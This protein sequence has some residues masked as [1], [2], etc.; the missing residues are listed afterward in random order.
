M[1]L[2]Q[3]TNERKFMRRNR[4]LTQTE[5]GRIRRGICPPTKQSTALMPQQKARN[6]L[7][8]T[9][10]KVRIPLSFFHSLFSID[11]CVVRLRD[12]ST[13][14]YVSILE[15]NAHNPGQKLRQPNK[16]TRK[17]TV[18]TKATIPTILDTRRWMNLRTQCLRSFDTLYLIGSHYTFPAFF[19]HFGSRSYSRQP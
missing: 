19:S 12:D 16:F 14:Y 3:I 11:V 6:Y 15:N 1:T 17:R 9:T 13:K 4:H 10:L 8:A 2:D 7:Q 18:T 5:I